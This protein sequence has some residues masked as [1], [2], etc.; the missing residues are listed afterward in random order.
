MHHPRADG[1]RGLRD[2]AG[3]LALHGVEG[4]RAALGQDA[5]QIDHHVGVAHRGR[6]RGGV[7]QIGLH[8]MDLADPADRLQMAGQFR[9]AHRDPDAVIAPRQRA[10]H[11]AAEKA[12]AAENRDEGVR[13][14]RPWAASRSRRCRWMAAVVAVLRIPPTNR[15]CD[16][17]A[18]VKAI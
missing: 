2:R 18:A 5:D 6:D 1:G 9:P 7:A 12:G 11:V 17:V 10:D 13:M 3:A 14:S 4:L 8:R 15:R 16:S